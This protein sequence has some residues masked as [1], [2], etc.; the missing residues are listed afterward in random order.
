V[1]QVIIA[2]RDDSGVLTSHQ[3]ASEGEAERRN[4][5]NE[6]LGV[7]EY[8]FW[9]VLAVIDMPSLDAAKAWFYSRRP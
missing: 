8:G 9:Q 3:V 2:F 7:E 1:K 5:Q 6:D 4:K